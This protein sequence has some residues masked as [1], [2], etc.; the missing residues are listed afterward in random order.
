MSTMYNGEHGITFIDAKANPNENIVK[1]SWQDF[2]LIPISSFCSPPPVPRYVLVDRPFSSDSNDYTEQIG[3]GLSFEDQPFQF[4]F[5][6]DH[7]K[8]ENWSVTKSAL[9][10][11]FNGKELKCILDDD[12]NVEYYGRFVVSGWEDGSNYSRITLDFYGH[13]FIEYD[14]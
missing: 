9:E 12:L 5:I 11:F 2:H 6:I 13:E 3:K 14:D 7:D 8:W 10:S 4:I 1:H